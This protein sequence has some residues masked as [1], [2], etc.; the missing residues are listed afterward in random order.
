MRFASSRSASVSVLRGDELHRDGAVHH[1]HEPRGQPRRPRVADDALLQ[2]ARL[3]DV[4]HVAA[5]IEHA[6]DARRIGQALHGLRDQLEAGLRDLRAAEAHLLRP[7]AARRSSPD[8]GTERTRVGRSTSTT[9]S[10]KASERVSP[11]HPPSGRLTDTTVGAQRLAQRGRGDG[12]DAVRSSGGAPHDRVREQ[13]LVHETGSGVRWPMGA[14]PP[15]A[16]P[17]TSRT[18]R[19]SQRSSARPVRAD[20]AARSASCAPDTS[21][22]TQPVSTGEHERLH[23]LRHVAA[24]CR[25]GVGRGAGRGVHAADLDVETEAARGRGP[26]STTLDGS[27]RRRRGL[28]GGRGRRGRICGL[29]IIPQSGVAPGAAIGRPA[30]CGTITADPALK[31][32]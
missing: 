23:D 13:R 7:A 16:K 31:A 32:T 24:A 11:R 26:R 10:V 17:V 9:A 6:V 5:V 22:S 21:S 12:E 27:L 29:S 18:R 15:M 4:E 8:S 28:G 1:R 20:T 19:A 14:T 30:H 3:A 25:G 2:A